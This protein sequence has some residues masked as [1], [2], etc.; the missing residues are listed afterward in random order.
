MAIRTRWERSLT[1]LNLLEQIDRLCDSA[2]T[3]TSAQDGLD[4]LPFALVLIF[5]RIHLYI[6]AHIHMSMIC[7][8]VV[9]CGGDCM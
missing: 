9:V 3:P 2:S 5:S 4:P 1:S 7:V 8:V 6:Y